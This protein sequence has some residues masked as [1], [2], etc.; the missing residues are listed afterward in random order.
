MTLGTIQVVKVTEPT[1]KVVADQGAVRVVAVGVQGPFGPPGAPGP[2]GPAG[3]VGPPGEQGPAGPS[4]AVTP[5]PSAQVGD[6]LFTGTGEIVADPA[7]FTYL[8]AQ[9]ALQIRKITGCVMDGGNF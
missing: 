9:R 7:E 3:A 4:G 6:V 8:L 1:T 2:A 5:P